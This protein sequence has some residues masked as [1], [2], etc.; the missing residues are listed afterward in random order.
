MCEDVEEVSPAPTGV[1]GM[2]KLKPSIHIAGRRWFQR[3]YGNTYHA[4]T[5]YQDGE[6]VHVSGK[7]YGYGEGYLQTAWEVLQALGIIPKEAEYGG[8]RALREDYGIGYSV[9]DVG[10]ERDL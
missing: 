8:T 6:A 9:A 3:S 7:R 4:V 2:S 5:I 10:R 1:F